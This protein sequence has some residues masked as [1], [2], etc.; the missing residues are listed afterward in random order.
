ML[1]RPSRRVREARADSVVAKLRSETTT[2][3][4]A[5][6]IL[7]NAVARGNVRK[8][9][10]YLR[11]IIRFRETGEWIITHLDPYR[12]EPEPQYVGGGRAIPWRGG[13]VRR[14]RDHG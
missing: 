1:N 13:S 11:R 3:P 8:P 4:E 7:R 14:S 9:D 5:F 2:S 12:S 10:D 6:E